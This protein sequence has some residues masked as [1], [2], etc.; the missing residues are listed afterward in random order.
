MNLISL[1]VPEFAPGIR[2]HTVTRT[3]A[4]HC[5][6]LNRPRKPRIIGSVLIQW[7]L[8]R[9]PRR[10][11]QCSSTSIPFPLLLQQ[12]L[13]FIML[14]PAISGTHILLRYTV[15]M[16]SLLLVMT[17]ANMLTAPSTN[18]TRVGVTGD[19]SGSIIHSLLQ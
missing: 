15:L 17:I 14:D 5:Q 8:P 13:I 2:C 9:I 10:L 18:G 3:D 19:T 12:K 1:S 11:K 7:W 16:L 6:I 4:Q